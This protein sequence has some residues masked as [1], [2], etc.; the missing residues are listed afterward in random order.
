MTTDQDFNFFKI[1][2]LQPRLKI[3]KCRIE[4]SENPLCHFDLLG[5]RK[6]S[7]PLLLTNSVARNVP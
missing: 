5:I 2:Q 3:S 1:S 6:R 4:A 7:S